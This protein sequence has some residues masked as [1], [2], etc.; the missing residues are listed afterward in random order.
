MEVGD[1]VVETHDH[2]G[3]GGVDA[4]GGLEVVEEGGVLERRPVYFLKF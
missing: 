1:G 2:L 3:G 4:V